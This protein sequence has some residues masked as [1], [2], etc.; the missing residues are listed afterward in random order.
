MVTVV[1]GALV[2]TNLYVVYGDG[3]DGALVV[4][5]LWVVYGDCIDGALVVTNLWIVYGD[6]VDG[7]FKLRLLRVRVDNI[8][9]HCGL[10]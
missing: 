7:L 6:R 2:V 5:N 10:G 4:T 8:D 1:D 9:C 3:V